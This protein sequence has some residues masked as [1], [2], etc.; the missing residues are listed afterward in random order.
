MV[1]HAVSI[2]FKLI[3]RSRLER[4]QMLT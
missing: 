4:G 2:A 3:N 1:P